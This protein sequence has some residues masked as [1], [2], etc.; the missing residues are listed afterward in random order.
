[1]KRGLWILDFPFKFTRH[2]PLAGRYIH[3]ASSNIRITVTAPAQIK[4]IDKQ[5]ETEGNCP[6]FFI[7]VSSKYSHKNNYHD[8]RVLATFQSSKKTLN[9]L[10][11]FLTWSKQTSTE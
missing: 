10:T 7:L 5:E 1:V 8:P 4:H 9:Q 3:S 6:G 2:Q 11:R